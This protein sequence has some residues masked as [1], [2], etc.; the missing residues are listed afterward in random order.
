MT[1]RS[2][3]E[4]TD[5]ER[6]HEASQALTKFNDILRTTWYRASD[7][8]WI[9]V[10]LK[11][12]SISVPTHRYANDRERSRIIEEIWNE[13]FVFGRPFIRYALLQGPDQ[14]REIVIKMDHGVYDGTLFRIFDDQFSIIQRG[15]PIPPHPEFKEFA[16]H[17]WQSEKTDSL[18]FWKDSLKECTFRYLETSD[19]VI[20]KSELEITETSLDTYANACK[21]TPSIIFQT[22]FQLWLARLTASDDICFDYLLSG[23]NVELPNPQLI[24]GTLANFLPFRSKL[25]GGDT[26]IKEYLKVT[27][28]FFWAATEHGNVGLES[29]YHAADRSRTEYGNRV[30]FL[31]QPF[32]PASG[33]PKEEM[34]WI[35][36]AQ[37]EVRMYQPYGLVIEVS[38]VLKGHKVKVMYDETL[39]SK[40][41]AKDFAA[42]IVGLVDEIVKDGGDGEDNN[43]DISLGKFLKKNEGDSKKWLRLQNDEQ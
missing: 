2:L 9:G 26:S 4:S 17:I 16:S 21:V 33:P 3:P 11:D 23:R 18:D 19:P 5:I 40:K 10:V 15:E 43:D 13:H 6:W 29:I 8:E 39:F 35:V 12:D 22:A 32:E 31:F 34:R 25:V 27:Q 41:D 20:T 30:L 7:E 14:K 24:N 37:S 1:I 36:M 38:K 42:E 28:D